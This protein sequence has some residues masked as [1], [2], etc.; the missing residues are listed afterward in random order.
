MEYGVCPMSYDGLVIGSCSLCGGA[1]RV[2]AVWRGVI[3]P[4]PTCER[5]GAIAAQAQAPVI[6]MVPR[7]HYR[8]S[9]TEGTSLYYS[10]GA[11]P[12][13]IEYGL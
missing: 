10:P 3:P 11:H 4:T 1:V 13:V 12:K 8:V 5:C 6:P 9:F 2:P 7:G